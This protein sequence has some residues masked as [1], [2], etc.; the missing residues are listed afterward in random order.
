[1]YLNCFLEFLNILQEEHSQ[2]VSSSFPEKIDLSTILKESNWLQFRYFKFC[3]RLLQLEYLKFHCLANIV[4]M[5]AVRPT[6]SVF[7]VNRTTAS[8]LKD[9]L[10]LFG[11]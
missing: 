8:L 1:M 5:H 10:A 7:E 11:K 9:L 2:D 3:I 6:E 4:K